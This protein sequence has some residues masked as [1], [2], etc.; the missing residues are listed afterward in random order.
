MPNGRP[1]GGGGPPI[2]RPD[3]DRDWTQGSV[4]KNVLLLAWPVIVNS[5]V[6]QFDMIIVMVWIAW[7][8]VKTVAGVGVAGTLTMLISMFRM[9]VTTGERAMITRCVG[10]DDI[11]G[12]NHVVLQAFWLNIALGI[13]TVVIGVMLAEPFMR[14]MGVE[15]EVARQGV[16]YMRI[17]FFGSAVMSFSMIGNSVMQ[18]SGDTVTPMYIGLVTRALHI[19]IAPCLI[20]GWGFFP[21]LEVTGAALA[22]VITNGVGAVISMWVLASGRTRLRLRFSF[23]VSPRTIWEMLKIGLPSSMNSAERSIARTFLTRILTSFG[24]YSIAAYTIAQRVDQ[25]VELASQ[26]LGQAG[27]ILVGQNLGAG[28][29]D[30]S[31]RAAWTA[32]GYGALASGILVIFVFWRAELLVRI[33]NSDPELVRMASTYVRIM[34]IQFAAMCGAMIF[35]NAL[36]SAGDTV[37]PM[38]ASIATLWGIELPL[39]FLLSRITDWG[40]YSIAAATVAA[41]SVRV[42]LYMSWF[43][44]GKWREKKISLEEDGQ[45]RFAGR[46]PMM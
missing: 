27:G 11:E 29:P 19:G 36:N 14:L 3:R 32:M 37:P 38:I 31:Y 39:A 44:W 28:R 35:S 43:Q 8:G 18:S 21:R 33:F 15:E 41:T 45:I 7:L 10:A 6:M 22:S 42:L 17:M 16:T 34:S 40:L 2:I 30:R 9:G 1:G 23:R 25:I 13:V 46:R 12:A 24:T 5:I 20:F 26:G 4:S